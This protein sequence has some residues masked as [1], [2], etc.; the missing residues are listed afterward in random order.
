MQRRIN[1]NS[2]VVAVS[3]PALIGGVLGAIVALVMPR[4]DQG[5]VLSVTPASAKS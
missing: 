3:V 5:D 2:A 1:Q 4:G